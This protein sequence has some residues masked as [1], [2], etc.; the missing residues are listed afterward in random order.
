[1]TKLQGNMNAPSTFVA[2]LETVANQNWYA[3]I[4]A[5]NHVKTN[6]ENLAIEEEY[7]G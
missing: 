4:G 6:L 1:M 3:N 7:N 5:T 2:I